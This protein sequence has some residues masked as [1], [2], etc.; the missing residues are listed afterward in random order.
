MLVAKR[1][2]VYEKIKVIKIKGINIKLIMET[3][4][5]ICAFKPSFNDKTIQ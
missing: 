2:K 4:T 1:L 5:P 3:K